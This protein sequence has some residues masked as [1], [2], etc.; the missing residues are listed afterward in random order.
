MYFSFRMKDR[1][2]RSSREIREP[3]NGVF[4]G[5]V[6]AEDRR[7]GSISGRVSPSGEEG[8]STV[9]T[10]VSLIG[11]E[12]IQWRELRSADPARG[13]SSKRYAHYSRD[14]ACTVA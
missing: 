8:L 6:R 1:L 9:E 10:S 4:A 2:K 11:G 12:E 5:R 14:P 7:S 3:S 13:I